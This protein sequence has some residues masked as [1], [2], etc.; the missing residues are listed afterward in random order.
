MDAAAVTSGRAT[1]IYGLDSLAE[2]RAPD[3]NFTRFLQI[4]KREARPTGRTKTI[5]AF[6]LREGLRSQALEPL[7]SNGL[8]LTMLET[9]PLAGKP[10]EYLFFVD[11]EGDEN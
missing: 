9:R 1:Y 6:T 4:G 7:I 11:F 3:G 5:I 10:L 2:A 8:R